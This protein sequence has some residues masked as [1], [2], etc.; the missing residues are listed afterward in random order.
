MISEITSDDVM[1]VNVLSVHQMILRW[2]RRPVPS[3]LIRI[4]I[5][6][7]KLLSKKANM[8]VMGLTN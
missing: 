4:C 1:I 7:D 2:V 5:D 8:N 3:L 6:A